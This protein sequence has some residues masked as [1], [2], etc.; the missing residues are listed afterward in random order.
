M[1]RFVQIKEREEQRW[2]CEEQR[3]D[4]AEEA[5]LMS[6]DLSR[7]IGQQRELYNYRIQELLNKKRQNQQGLQNFSNFSQY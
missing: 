4:I 2:E 6:M 1:E 3:K 7:M 5:M